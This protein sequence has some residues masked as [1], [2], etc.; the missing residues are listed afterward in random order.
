MIVLGVDPGFASMGFAAVAVDPV[1]DLA[2]AVWVVRTEKSTKKGN[3]RA[4][5]DNVRRAM[6]LS[7]RLEEAVANWAPLAVAAETMS[8]PRN[9]GAAAKVA[10]AWGVLCSVA[11]RHGLPLVQASPQQVKL[12]ICGSKT[13]SKEEVIAAVRKRW[14]E[15]E[16]PK[17]VTLQEHAADAAAVV[18][19]CL[20]SEVLR[21]A[22]KLGR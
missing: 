11:K 4:S 8:W 18:V 13:A 3:V 22:R 6:E 5:E 16:L 15:L 9:A 14:P 17:Q 20:D 12:A 7:F 21:M 1:G 19:A 10:L 2:N